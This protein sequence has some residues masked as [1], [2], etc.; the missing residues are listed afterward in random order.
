M[1][2]PPDVP[3]CG[4]D[5]SVGGWRSCPDDRWTRCAV[6]DRRTEK[7]NKPR[8]GPDPYPDYPPFSSEVHLGGRLLAERL[9]RSFGVVETKIAGQPRT[10]LR[11]VGVVSQINVFVLHRAPQSL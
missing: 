11:T 1:N 4:S 5:S 8:S 6:S 9:V 3:F 7:P 10:Q 2:Q